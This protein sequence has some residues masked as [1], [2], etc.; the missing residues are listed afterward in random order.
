MQKK[1]TQIFLTGKAMGFHQEVH[2][3]LQGYTGMFPGMWVSLPRLNQEVP[4]SLPGKLEIY[5]DKFTD[6]LLE[7]FQF[8]GNLC[9]C[10]CLESHILYA[11][12]I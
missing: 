11:I 5:L 8:P 6:E 7:N 12:Q 10:I 1:S 2:R 9:T 4:V 3:D